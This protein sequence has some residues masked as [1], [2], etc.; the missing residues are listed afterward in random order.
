MRGRVAEVPFPQRHLGA[1]SSLTQL[2]PT[3]T[4]MHLSHQH[5]TGCQWTIATRDLVNSFKIALKIHGPVVI[6]QN[7]YTLNL[8]NASIDILCPCKGHKIYGTLQIIIIIM[9]YLSSLQCNGSYRPSYWQPTLAI[10]CCPLDAGQ[11]NIITDRQDRPI[12]DF[13]DTEGVPQST[14]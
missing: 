6:I 9:G 10:A 13:R 5:G 7:C 8:G 12:A 11:A 4:N 14:N 1:T 2:S 3:F